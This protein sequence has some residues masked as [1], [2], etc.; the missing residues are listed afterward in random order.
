MLTE[1]EIAE[2]RG[3]LFTASTSRAGVAVGD[4]YS[5]VLRAAPDRFL[6][7]EDVFFSMDFA[8]D[9]SGR[10]TVTLDAYV[11]ISNGN[12]WAYTGGT[13]APLGRPVN[14]GK[15]NDVA[16]ST[17]SLGVSPDISGDIDY[18]FY[19]ASYTL[20]TQGNRNTVTSN[21]STFFE[22]DRKI[23][24]A[25]GQEMLARTR[26]AGDAVGTGTVKTLLF[27]SEVLIA[28][29]PKVFG[30]TLDEMGYTP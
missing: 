10:Y 12:E 11:D 16:A 30:A 22:G 18:A 19:F 23:I 25:P 9:V 29:V 6:I 7:I 14:A 8:A 2:A 13:T 1:K 17:I 15:V 5:S 27:V 21:E 28:D 3:K 20:D 24:L 26:T 4:D